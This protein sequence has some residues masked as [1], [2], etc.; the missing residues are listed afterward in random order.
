MA[1]HQRQ[2][3]DADITQFDRGI[4]SRKNDLLYLQNENDSNF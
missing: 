3:C 4:I 1:V 2:L